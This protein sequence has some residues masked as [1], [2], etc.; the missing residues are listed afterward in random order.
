[1]K[2]IENINK[3]GYTLLEI[4]VVVMIIGVLTTI[5][6]TSI[7]KVR[8]KMRLKHAKTE[9]EMLA[10]AVRQLAWDTGDWPSG[11]TRLDDN[12]EM[13]D[14]TTGAAGII[15]TDGSFNNWK[16]PYLANIPDDPWGSKYFFD[17]DYRVDGVNR[18]VVGSYGPNR[19]GQNRYYEDNIYVVIQ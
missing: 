18:I 14:L 17:P 11:R 9:L 15:K 19:T 12:I 1:M 2:R 4:M 3:N 10:A 8:Q 16:G 5:A 7:T 13:W 6:I